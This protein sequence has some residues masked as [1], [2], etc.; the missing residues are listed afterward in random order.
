MERELVREPTET[1][2]LPVY[3]F[4]ACKSRRLWRIELMMF[5]IFLTMPQC[6][7]IIA[8]PTVAHHFIPSSAIFDRSINARAPKLH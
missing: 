3:R 4:V 8:L 5:R 2:C 6:C 1:V 7:R